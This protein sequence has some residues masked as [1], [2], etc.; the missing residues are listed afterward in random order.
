ME[1]TQAMNAVNKY[2]KNYSE[3]GFWEKVKRYA[4][5]FGVKPIYILLLL[6]YLIPKVSFANKA[7]IIGG[8]GYFISPF[9]IIPDAIPVAGYIDDM[10][11]LMFV[12]ST[13][14]S[15]LDDEIRQKAK[16]NLRTFFVNFDENIIKEL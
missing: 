5:K 15:N 4:L 2:S 11:V 3:K 14:K 6:F 12:Y 10:A 1:E 13:V 9:D 16:D 7:I 8:L